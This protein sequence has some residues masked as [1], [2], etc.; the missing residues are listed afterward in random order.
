MDNQETSWSCEDV[1]IYDMNVIAVT[2]VLGKLCRRLICPILAQ[3]KLTT[4]PRMVYKWHVRRQMTGESLEDDCL[5][6][7]SSGDFRSSRST[8]SSSHEATDLP[9]AEEGLAT[10]F[11]LGGQSHRRSYGE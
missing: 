10:E 6:A 4:R 8:A 2:F 5:V 7:I 3:V 11:R 9:H 1:K